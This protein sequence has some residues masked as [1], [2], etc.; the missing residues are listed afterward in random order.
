MDRTIR[1][2][3]SDIDGVWTDGGMYLGEFGEEFKKFNV[4]DGWG[5]RMLKEHGIPLCIITGEDSRAVELR[6]KKLDV[7]YVF[8]GV[9]DKVSVAKEICSKLQVTLQETAFIGDDLNDL[10]LLQRV[11]ISACPADAYPTVQEEV[12]HV[13]IKK[14]GQGVFREFVEYI[15][16]HLYP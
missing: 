16:P 6:A 7:D 14:G 9:D 2:V 1:L 8:V 15:R 10:D 11:G 3:I 5:V 12:D 13:L 4:R